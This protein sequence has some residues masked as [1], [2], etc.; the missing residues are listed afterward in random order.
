MMGECQ[1]DDLLDGLEA[2]LAERATRPP[3]PLMSSAV[4]ELYEYF[5]QW[6]ACCLQIK[7]SQGWLAQKVDD[8]KFRLMGSLRANMF[9]VPQ[10]LS[11]SIDD[12]PTFPSVATV[13]KAVTDFLPKLQALRGI[14]ELIKE[15]KFFEAQ[16]PEQ[17]CLDLTQAL[18]ARLLESQNRVIA[19]E[20][21]TTALEARLNRLERGR[22]KKVKAPTIKRA[23][24]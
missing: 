17:Q 21:A 16:A 15:A 23:A 19:L 9:T 3:D 10:L 1:L 18:F 5:R 4:K 24:A 20:A 12:R 14:C 7:A 2:A 13:R 11:I 22:R 8:W 6:N